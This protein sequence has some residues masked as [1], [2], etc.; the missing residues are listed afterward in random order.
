M[1]DQETTTTYTTVPPTIIT[2]PIRYLDNGTT[3]SYCPEDID[4]TDGQ[5]LFSGSI[6]ANQE[7]CKPNAG[8]AGN[9]YSFPGATAGSNNSSSNAP[10][11]ICP[12][13]WRVTL[14]AASNRR[15]WSYLITKTY[16]IS[17]SGFNDSSVRYLPM[18]FVR[19]GN[20]NQGSLNNRASNGYYW[21]SVADSSN[22]AYYLRFYSGLLDPQSN[23]SSKYLG[24]SVRCI[25]R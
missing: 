18:S 8:N 17:T 4:Y 25:A 1:F 22:V 2:A 12:R 3:Q 6:Y 23:Y 14:N 19:S 20:Y 13:G 5:I 24:F 9:W 11:S 10:D 21:S 16:N 7:S 15:S